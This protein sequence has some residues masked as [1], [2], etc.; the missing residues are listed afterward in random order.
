MLLLL[1]GA[2]TTSAQSTP[3][4]ARRPTIGVALEGGGALGLAH[5][6]VLRWFEKNHIPVDY[7]VGTSMGGLVGGLYATGHSPSQIEGL[8]KTMDWP[9]IIGG[10]TP[11][12]DLSFRRKQ[13]HRAIPTSLTLGFRRGAAPPSA[14]NAGQQISMEI[15]RATLPYS[16]VESF[17]DLP[18]PF[19]CVSTELISGQLHVF[20][21]GPIA[22]AM[23]STM[24]LPGVFAPIRD[25]DSLYIDG[26]LVDNLPT[27]VV[28]EMGPDIVIAVHLQ[29]S[30]ATANDIRSLFSV[31]GRSIT[32]G[33]AN[34]ELRGMEGAD[35]VI[36]VDVSRFNSLEYE[37]GDELIEQGFQA[38]EAK[39]M[40]LRP[41]ALNQTDWDAYLKNRDGRRQAPIPVPRFIAVQGVN[42]GAQKTI[43][44]SLQQIIGKPL[45][46]SHLEADL[47]RLTGQGRFDGASY[48]LTRKNG[49][50][51]LLVIAHEQEYAPPV[52][53]LGFEVSG[54]QPDNVNFTQAGR[55]TFMEI[56]GAGSELRNDFQFGNTYGIESELY[57]PFA[58]RSQWFYAPRISANIS[59]QRIYSNA[60]PVAQYSFGRAAGAL[61]FGYAV[62]RFTEVR[63][64]YETGY[65]DA[66]LRLGTPEFSSVKGRTGTSKLRFET[67]HLDHPIIPRRG[68][69]GRFSFD[70]VD[71][72]PGAKSAYPSVRSSV[73]YFKTVSRAASVFLTAQGGTTLG[74]RNT[75][76]PQFLMGGVSGWVAYGANELRGNQF[77]LLRAGYMHS[78]FR[79][80]PFLGGNVYGVTLF[81]AG[82]MFA[83]PQ[84]SRLPTDGVAGM[85]AVTAVGPVFVGGA[86]GDTGHAKW[87]FSLG[88]VF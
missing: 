85:I 68:Y 75:G 22:L 25:G 47:T 56:A 67:L 26:A 7:I 48:G 86:V 9:L 77:Y 46:T 43:E 84:V 36:K 88:H 62:S 45:D 33:V 83:S 32:V 12:E 37:K 44:T 69:V 10:E 30:A 23:R 16:T 11:Y 58:G 73:S 2:I 8:V 49:E 40:I 54:A 51:G 35:L 63:A 57:K 74:Y 64:G 66:S 71:T 80:P 31:L 20:D 3:A 81:E 18:I 79:M 59:Q 50:D 78:L 19:R 14:L 34:T 15:D 42:G 53:Q 39:S 70:W 52:L 1:V 17:D 6:G 29:V 72:S 76:V 13:D 27:D 82:K 61:D 87:F 55:L 4:P 21:H 24:S 65:L 41:Y 38:T 60:L 5:I 28:R